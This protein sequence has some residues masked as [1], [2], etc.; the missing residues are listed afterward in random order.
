MSK[1]IYQLWM[2]RNQPSMAAYEALSETQQKALMEQNEASTK[3]VGARELLSCDC[4]WA[5]ETYTG[6]GITQFP[7]VAARIKHTQ[8]LQ[9][10]GWFRIVDAFTLLGTA[11]DAPKAVTFPKPIYELWVI[12]NNPVAMQNFSLLSKDEGDA[13]W[14]KHNQGLERYQSFNWLFCD[15]SWCDDQ[16]P[17]FGVNVY[18]SIEAEQFHKSELAKIQWGKYFDAFSILGV[19]GS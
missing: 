3:G 8:N 13:M 9:K 16:H 6:W 5:N 11:D 7:D 17:N 14:A 19:P 2:A 12:K 10:A 15:S 4:A 1:P 18:P